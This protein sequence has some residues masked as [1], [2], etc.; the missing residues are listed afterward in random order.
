M[1]KKIKELLVK[2]L[3]DDTYLND[4]NS[5]T[6]IINDIG[7]DSLQLIQ[8]LMALEDELDIE[9]DYENL[10]Y[11]WFESI[12]TLSKVLEQYKK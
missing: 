3:G 1:E 11:E 6:S 9:F 10:Q 5:D 12:A 4:W 2:V 7:L 8:F